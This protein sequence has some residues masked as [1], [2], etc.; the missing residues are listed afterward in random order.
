[1]TPTEMRAI[2]EEIAWSQKAAADYARYDPSLVRKMARGRA[3][4]PDELARWLIAVRVA[5]QPVLDLID[6]PPGRRPRPPARATLP[7][8]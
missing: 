5:Y 2:L 3:P 1:M 6:N 7:D 4:I 8:Q